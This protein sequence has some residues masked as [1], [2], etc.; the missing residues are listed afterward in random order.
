[1]GLF[2][3]LAAVGGVLAFGLAG[4]EMV[5]LRSVAGNT[6]EEAF[7]Q[8]MGIFSFGMAALVVIGAVVADRLLRTASVI[9][10]VGPAGGPGAYAPVAPSGPPVAGQ[11]RCRTRTN[12]GQQCALVMNHAGEHR[13]EAQVEAGG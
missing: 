3:A 5:S 2:A 7:F 8:A 10:A 11:W 1:M 6:V 12:D 4:L 13:T 9:Q